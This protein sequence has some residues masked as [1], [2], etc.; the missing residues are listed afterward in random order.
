MQRRFT[1]YQTT[2]VHEELGVQP[3]DDQDEKGDESPWADVRFPPEP[4]CD[5]GRDAPWN[6]ETDGPHVL[7]WQQP[8]H[9]M[10]RLLWERRLMSRRTWCRRQSRELGH[11]LQGSVHE[12]QT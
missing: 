4:M 2:C 10:G 12:S 8:C 7:G 6:G 3:H 5:V 1:T 11:G 9:G